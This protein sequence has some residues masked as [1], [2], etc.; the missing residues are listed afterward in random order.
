MSGIGSGIGDVSG[1]LVK[2]TAGLKNFFTTAEKIIA[3]PIKS[4]DSMF[5]YTKSGAGVVEDITK[6]MFNK[7]KKQAGNWWSQL[8]SMVD[9]DGG[10]ATGSGTRKKFI[11]EAMK[12]SKRANYK[13]SGLGPNYYDCSG[14]VYEALKHIG[15]T[16]SGSTTVPEYNSTHS[17]S[18]GKAVHGDLAFWGAGGSGHVGIVTST[19]GNGRMWNAENPTDGIKSAPIKGFMGGFAGLR[20]I[21]QLNGGKGDDSSKKGIGNTK[22]IKSQVGSGFFKFMHKLA[23]MFGDNSSNT[24]SSA[25]PTGDHMHW[26]KQA[27]I[28]TSQYSA[29]NYI[30][31]HESGWN[32]TNSN[33]GSGAYG[34]PQALPGSKMASAGSDWKTNAITQ[35]KWMKKYVGRYGDLH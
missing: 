21:A 14:L 16:L 25:K 3:H 6:G 34:L 11:E 5:N 29:Y 22:G 15:V 32:P 1:W 26:L 35:I 27:G 13:Y 2:K 7:V 9:L 23:D 33:P 18:W 10:G 30:I 28:P 12:L 24:G 4:L 20:R 31:S 19:N 8:W 17:V